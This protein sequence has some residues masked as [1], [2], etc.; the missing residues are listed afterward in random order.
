MGGHMWL[1]THGSSRGGYVL[2]PCSS[3]GQP[4]VG[5]CNSNSEGEGLQPCGSSGWGASQYGRG[6]QAVAVCGT[7]GSSSVWESASSR[8][9]FRSASVKASRSSTTWVQQQV[10]GGTELEHSRT[11]TTWGQQ[12]VRGGTELE[13]S[14]TRLGLLGGCLVHGRVWGAWQ[15]VGCV[16]WCG[17]CRVRGAWQGAGCM[18]GCGVHGRVWGAWQGVGCVA[19]CGVRGRVWGAWQGVG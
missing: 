6:Q 9:R 7:A 15:G 17:A 12:Q 5:T 14:H 13:P 8:Q 10:R 3:N 19:G 4:G 18:A 2:Q 11:S 16:A 1:G